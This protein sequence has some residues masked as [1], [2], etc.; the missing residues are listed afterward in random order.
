MIPLSTVL[1][2]NRE[3]VYVGVLLRNL[4]EVDLS[5]HVNVVESDSNYDCVF[6]F[7]SLS[8]VFSLPIRVIQNHGGFWVIVGFLVT[9]TNLGASV[10]VLEYF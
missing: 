7:K 10:L 2:G 5:D 3:V 9:L 4:I 1:R 8:V 6:E